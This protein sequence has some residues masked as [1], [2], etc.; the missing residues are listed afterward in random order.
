MISMV[1]VLVVPC[2]KVS[3]CFSD[4]APFNCL[5]YVQKL[6]STQCIKIEKYAKLLLIMF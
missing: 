4:Y 3:L 2:M 5:Y 1:F 6:T